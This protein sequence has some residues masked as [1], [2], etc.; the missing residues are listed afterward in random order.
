MNPQQQAMKTSLVII[1]EYDVVQLLP[2]KRPVK[3]ND[4]ISAAQYHTVFV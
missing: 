1:I 2:E 4:L 3:S